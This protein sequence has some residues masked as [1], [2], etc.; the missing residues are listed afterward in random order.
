[1]RLM[2]A[3]PRRSAIKRAACQRLNEPC[4]S[5]SINMTR[6]DAA[7]WAARWAVKV[8]LPV[9]PLHEAKGIMF[10]D[11]LSVIA[12][13]EATDRLRSESPNR[14]DGRYRLMPLNE[15]VTIK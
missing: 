7:T 10:I 9:P 3:L 11:P 4:T 6:E 14:T 12:A 1:M 13:R 8:L 5:A 15:S 2:P